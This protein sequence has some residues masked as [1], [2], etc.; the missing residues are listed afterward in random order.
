MGTCVR[1]ADRSSSPRPPAHGS[2]PDCASSEADEAVVR[3]VGDHLG[4]LA[5]ADLAWRCRL[6]QQDD[7]RTIRKRA[8]TGQS[9]S[10]WAGAITRTSGDQWQRALANLADRRIMLRRSIRTIRSRLAVPVGSKQDR[11]RGYATRTERFAKRWRLQHLEAELVEV[12]DRLAGRRMSVCRGGRRL[13]KQR[14]TLDQAKVS[15]QQWRARWQAERMFLTADGEAAK[16]WGNET[17]RVHPDQHWLELRLPNPLA[18][19]SNTPGRAATYRLACSGS[20]SS[21]GARGRPERGPSGLLGAGR[22]RQPGRAT[23][24]HPTGVG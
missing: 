22:E 24:H 9:S 12:E 13:A 1:S 11:V 16:P 3:A 10:R 20:S 17:I 15:E 8:L 5:S 14:H 7:L 18:H 19:L 6:G 2:E 4:R 21:P 23:A